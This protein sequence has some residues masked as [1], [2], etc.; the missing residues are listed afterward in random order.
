M[1]L[2]VSDTDDQ[3]LREAV[4]AGLVAHNEAAAGPGGYRPLN[5]ALHQDGRIAGGLIGY[6]FHRWLFI[7]LF[8]VDAA[9][10]GIGIGTRMIG[11]AEDEA[12]A[13]GCIG[14]HLDSFSFQARPFYERHGYRVF[15]TLGDFPPGHMRYFLSKRIA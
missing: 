15:G 9:L 5:I 6:S 3:A 2:S 14:V 8:H 12:R 1:K 10:R 4:L 11:M 7:H 13:R